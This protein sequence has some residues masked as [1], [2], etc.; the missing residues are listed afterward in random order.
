MNET[1]D[2]YARIATIFAEHYG[3]LYSLGDVKKLVKEDMLK[4]VH[5]PEE[6]QI[7][8]AVARIDETYDVQRALLLA[9]ALVRDGKPEE[10]IRHYDDLI[11]A[12]CEPDM[13]YIGKSDA[14]QALDKPDMALE[15]FEQVDIGSLN[16]KIQ[17]WA[18]LRKSSLL[19]RLGKLEASIACLN[20]SI[21]L[22]PDYADAYFNKG[23]IFDSFSDADR[24]QARLEES[25]RCYDAA[26]E[27]NPGHADAMYNRG[28]VLEK[29]G[30][31][32]EA[33]ASFKQAIEANPEVAAAY[34]SCGSALDFLG[35]YEDALQYYAKALQKK[36]DFSGA[37]HN[38]AHSLYFLGRVEEASCFFAMAT[39][40]KPDLPMA[41]DLSSLIRERLEFDHGM[42]D[43]CR[44]C[45]PD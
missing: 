34:E 26:I 16:P 10:A 31:V 2:R 35:K 44:I 45:N 32:E 38:M 37:M 29:L 28:L 25:V 33:I 8:E 43:S 13:A 41:D 19:Y 3:R 42:H 17:A 9:S 5:H 21:D 23:V 27:S 20:R 7:N 36:P 24:N 4:W 11:L 12:D 6:S 40:I 30:R 14:L 15:S 22:R 18:L 39:R 1:E